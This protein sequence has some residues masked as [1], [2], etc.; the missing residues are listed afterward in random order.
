MTVRGTSF[1]PA[2]AAGNSAN[3]EDGMH[4]YCIVDRFYFL[5]EGQSFI[6]IYL[7]PF[8]IDLWLSFLN[9]QGK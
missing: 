6:C 3:A 1:D 4:F 8:C 7:K 9:I 5:R 2:T